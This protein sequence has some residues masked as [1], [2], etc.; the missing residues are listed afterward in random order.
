MPIQ[1]SL[2]ISRMRSF[3]ARCSAE[4]EGFGALGR[5]PTDVLPI[6]L[7]TIER[8]TAISRR[9]RFLLDRPA[10]PKLRHRIRLLCACR[11]CDSLL[12]R[13]RLCRFRCASILAYGEPLGVSIKDEPFT[14]NQSH[15]QEILI[16]FADLSGK[17][18][19]EGMTFQTSLPDGREILPLSHHVSAVI[20]EIDCSFVAHTNSLDRGSA[21]DLIQINLSDEFLTRGWPIHR[22]QSH[23]RPDDCGI[24]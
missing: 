17:P 20:R 15:L 16:T 7:S 11:Q 14:R 5:I 18:V 4:A 23:V 8:S 6:S 13:E 9:S 2:R 10:S 22:S 21:T 24:S 3:D 19:N 1:R 12:R